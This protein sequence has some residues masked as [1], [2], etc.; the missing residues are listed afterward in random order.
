MYEGK[1]KGKVSINLILLMLFVS[2]LCVYFQ[3]LYFANTN[4]YSFFYI[5]I[6]IFVLLFYA[7]FKVVVDTENRMTLFFLF[8]MA[9]SS[10]L[11]GG[12][13]YFLQSLLLMVALLVK[14]KICDFKRALFILEASGFFC[15]VGCLMQY[16]LNDFYD[17]LIQIVFK[18][19][20]YDT[21][22]RLYS[23]DKS[24]CGFMPQTSHAAG[25]ILCA[26]FIAFFDLK[27]RKHKGVTYIELVI[28]IVALLLTNKRA[29]FLFGAVTFILGMLVG[30][31][32]GKKQKRI[33][34]AFAAVFI[35]I[36]LTYMFLPVINSQSTLASLVYT[37]QNLNNSDVDITSDRLALAQEALN[38]IKEAPFWGNGWGS[39]KLNSLYKTDAHNVYLQVFAES[40]IFVFFLFCSTLFINVKHCVSTLHRNRYYEKYTEVK[41]LLKFSFCVQVFF[42]L[43]CLTGNC[44][45]NIDFWALYILAVVIM[46]IIRREIKNGKIFYNYY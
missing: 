2:P 18:K 36:S 28:L 22:I 7:N 39:F 13:L 31:N 12:I 17:V 43:Y 5:I 25:I 3:N 34:M 26:I 44:L 42:V 1:D 38:L 41:M 15:A 24:T 32:R 16:F 40:G 23:W 27:L 6:T 29:H 35:V 46:N 33:I 14:Y 19:D 30:E 10:L 11:G 45:Y 20:A 21:I 4:M 8:L 37:F 9:I